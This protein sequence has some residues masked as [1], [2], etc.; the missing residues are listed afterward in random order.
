LP[1]LDEPA[2]RNP[3]RMAALCVLGIVALALGYLILENLVLAPRRQAAELATVAQIVEQSQRNDASPASAPDN[4]IAVLPFVDMSPGKDQEYMSDGIAEELLN[5]L[6]KI[7]KLRVIARTSSFSFKGKEADVATIADQLH[8][9]YVLE[10]SVRKS[11][12]RIRITAQLIRAADSSHLWSETYDRTLD[13]VFG[14]Q[15]EISEA[16]VTQ[17][18]IRLLGAAPKA[19][20]ADPR[21]YPL[22]LQARQLYR[23]STAE[24]Y[25][26]SITLYQKALE[27]DPGYAPAWVALASVY[28]NQG[29]S[30][31][32]P[33]AEALP[34]AR[35]AVDKALAI[36]PDFAPALALLA[37]ISMNYD[38]DLAAAAAY[39]QRALAQSPEDIGTLLNAARLAQSIGRTDLAIAF[40][41]FVIARDPVSSRAQ[42]NL[43]IDLAF[44]GRPDEAIARW[45]TALALS[46]GYIGA[47]FN[48]GATQLLEGDY[49]AALAS[50]QSEPS[51]VWRAI[52]LP[53][54]YHA[55]GRHAESDAALAE[56][57]AKYEKESAYNIAYVLAYRGEVDRAFEWL[58]KAVAYQD[59]GLSDIMLQPEF[60]NIREDPRWTPFLQRIGRA[61]EQLAA[62]RFDVTPPSGEAAP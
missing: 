52:G 1:M 23:Q 6:A 49:K 54:V 17:L 5:L 24:G 13:D 7:P 12:N 42:Y 60:A 28:T 40:D 56:L 20:K 10:G 33:L 36:D 46:P 22:F 26:Q 45:R 61:P 25:A 14:V 21:A 2:R 4:S 32:R 9:A 11:G 55:M 41:E 51:E 18:K 47:Q 3:F 15:D 57:I 27:I 50:M 31:L 34:L 59:G 16:V 19:P 39:L 38:G 37:W 30:G 8:V 43:G 48:I 35:Q 62:I 44:G 53:M 29:G 58:D